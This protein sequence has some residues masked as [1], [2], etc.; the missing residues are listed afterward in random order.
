MSI[1]RRRRASLACR[2][3]VELVTDY[4]EGA[5]SRTDRARFEAHLADCPHYSAYLEQIRMTIAAAGR[6]EPEQL[7]QE[8]QDD[9]VAL[10]RRWQETG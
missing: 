9:L 4:L 5:L 6:V 7:S 2:D 3:A 10:F 1:F 8:A